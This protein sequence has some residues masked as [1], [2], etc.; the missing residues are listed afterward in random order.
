MSLTATEQME[1]EAIEANE[2][3]AKAG[4]RVSLALHHAVLAGGEPARKVADFLHGTWLGHPLHPV[5]TDLT[6][7]AWTMGSVFDGIAGITGSRSMEQSADQLMIAG[8]VCAVPTA[9]T[10]L[11]DYS[12]FPERSAKTA[13]WHGLLNAVN[14]GLYGWSIR[15][16]RRGNRGRGVLLSSV[17]FG[18]TCVSAWLGGHLVYK[19][20]VGVNNSD[21][22]EGPREWTAVFDAA[23][24]REH[25]PET[26][27]FEGKPVLL[28]RD[29]D[30]IWALGNK[31]AHAGGPLNEGTFRDGCVQC[32]WH[33]SVFKV[34]DGSV[35]HGPA[36]QPQPR[37][38]TRTRDGQ[39][40]IRLARA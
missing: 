12:T 2:G 29:G 18:M 25:C 40:E 13:T 20:R 32:P 4:T 1:Q 27:D 24:L 19:E 5:L 39:V 10:G 3:V 38:E 16:R 28:Y 23:Q 31:C 30:A 17:A 37:F 34:A 7:G 22:F 21:T 36:T 15:E 9:L 11:T 14:V 26:I 8:V 6:I 35:V 33:D